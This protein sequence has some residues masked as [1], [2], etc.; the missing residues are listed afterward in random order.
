MP[1]NTNNTIELEGPLHEA[2]STRLIEAIQSEDPRANDPRMKEAIAAEIR[3]LVRSGTF[4]VDMRAE[5]PPSAGVLTA[6]FVLAI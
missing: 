5:I 4:K 2:I 6:R 3:D 1:K